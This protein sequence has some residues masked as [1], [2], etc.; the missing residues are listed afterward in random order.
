MN[1]VWTGSAVSSAVSDVQGAPK[2]TPK[3]RAEDKRL[4]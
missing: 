1:V 2:H 4:N 3:G